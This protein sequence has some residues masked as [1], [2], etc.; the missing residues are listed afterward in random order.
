MDYEG[1][2]RRIKE[3]YEDEEQAI[4]DGFRS[5]QPEHQAQAEMLLRGENETRVDPKLFK[6][7]TKR[8]QRNHMKKKMAKLSRKQNR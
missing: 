8:K 3:F 4:K 2:L 6:T 1:N 5:V 7:W